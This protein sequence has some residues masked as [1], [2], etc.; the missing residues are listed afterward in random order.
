MLN[1]KLL[2]FKDIELIVPNLHRCTLW[3]WI[4]A[5]K[6]PRSRTLGPR[7]ICWL[8]SEVHTWLESLKGGK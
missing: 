8:E 5:G 3:R 7:R 4:K 6:F 1:E 2:F